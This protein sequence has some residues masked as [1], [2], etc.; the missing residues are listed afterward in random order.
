MQVLIGMK[1]KTSKNHSATHLLHAA[2]KVLGE[3]VNQAGSLVESERLRFDFSHFGP[4]TQDEIDQVER[5]VNEEIWRVF[6]LIYKRCLLMK[7]NKWVLW[8]YSEKIRRYCAR[9]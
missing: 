5:R 9:C 4:M 1:E 8:R 3:H 7:Q 2:L 6:Q